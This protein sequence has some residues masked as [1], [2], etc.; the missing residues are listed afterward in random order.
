MLPQEVRTLSPRKCIILSPGMRPIL[1]DRIIY[2]ADKT[3]SKVLLK[4]PIV[5]PI[6]RPEPASAPSPSLPVEVAS[7]TGVSQPVAAEAAP[8]AVPKPT[9]RGT[10]APVAATPTTTSRTPDKGTDPASPKKPAG[11]RTRKKPAPVA[12]GAEQPEA[13]AAA[14]TRTPEIQQAAEPS[15]TADDGPPEWIPL[16]AETAPADSL[17]KPAVSATRM[18]IWDAISAAEPNLGKYGLPESQK[19]IGD[20]VSQ[21][22]GERDEPERSLAMGER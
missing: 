8:A 11:S 20:I 9:D 10:C 1:A 2:Y 13:K 22:P 21:L 18:A 5:K 17:V 12:A 7:K 19:W 6:A 16:P 4:A 15:R 3:F 14:D